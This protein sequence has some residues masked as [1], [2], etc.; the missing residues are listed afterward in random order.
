MIVLKIVAGLIG[1]FLLVFIIGG[2]IAGAT[3]SGDDVWD[4]VKQTL[5]TMVVL[6]I[7]V[8]FFAGIIFFITQ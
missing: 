6:P 1:Y 7:V 5:V 8:G 3:E 4:V 2:A